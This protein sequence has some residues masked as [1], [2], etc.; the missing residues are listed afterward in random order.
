MCCGAN[1]FL[2][3]RAV[4]LPLIWPN[5][6]SGALFAFV[7]SFDEPVISFFL[8]GVRDKTLPRMMF[9]DIE[10][11]LTPIIPAIAVMLTL[12]SIIVLVGA[13]GLRALATRSQQAVSEE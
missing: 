4:T 2:A 3:F 13:A 8:A 5:V 1:R 12:L 9:D 11:N 10:Q 7:I 6:L